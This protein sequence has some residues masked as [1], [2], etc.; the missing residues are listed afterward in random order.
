MLTNLPGHTGKKQEWAL[1]LDTE[2]P[3]HT[4][5]SHLAAQLWKS[6]ESTD[7]SPALRLL[8]I[9]AFIWNWGHNGWGP[10]PSYFSSG[11]TQIQ[12][13]A[14]ESYQVATTPYPHRKKRTS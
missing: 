4:H 5:L 13:S 10:E 6:M 8:S 3:K 1:N 7:T 12:L 14:L 9:S 11:V 2:A